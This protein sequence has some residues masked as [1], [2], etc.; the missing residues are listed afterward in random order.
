MRR[1]IERKTKR[2]RGM[3]DGTRSTAGLSVAEPSVDFACFCKICSHDY[4]MK[5]D[6]TNLSFFVQRERRLLD[7]SRRC[8]RFGL[9]RMCFCLGDLVMRLR[10]VLLHFHD[11]L[12]CGFLVRDLLVCLHVGFRISLRC[13]RS[14]RRRGRSRSNCCSRL[15][16]RSGCS[17]RRSLCEGSGGKQAGDQG[18]K[19]FIHGTLRG[20]RFT[21]NKFWG[22]SR[23]TH[24]KQ[25]ALTAITSGYK[26]F[27]WCLVP[28][29]RA[30]HR[31]GMSMT[32]YTADWLAICVALVRRRLPFDENLKR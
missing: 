27:K 20:F 3:P 19:Q 15:G 11:F 5:K 18:G 23:K 22:L 4:Q 30:S 8:G 6:R 1:V 24:C 29:H 31:V 28:C 32:G 16:G 25:P 7:G 21:Q 12:V 14:C 13:R 26:A 2:A 10:L 17:G 9:Q